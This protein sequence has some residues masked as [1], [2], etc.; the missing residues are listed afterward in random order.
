MYAVG[1]IKNVHAAQ[2][3]THTF[4]KK[5]FFFDEPKKVTKIYELSTSHTRKLLTL[6]MKTQDSH[7]SW[8]FSPV[9]LFHSK[10]PFRMS[11]SIGLPPCLAI[12][13]LNSTSS[14]SRARLV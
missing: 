14:S 1:S 10:C 11:S 3:P 8:G 4:P 2:I 13:A 5:F 9:P 12:S 6:L 7:V